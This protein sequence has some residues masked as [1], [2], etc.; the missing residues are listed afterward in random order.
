[1]INRHATI[2][3]SI[4]PSARRPIGILYINYYLLY[5]RYY[6]VIETIVFNYLL[7]YYCC[8]H[9]LPPLATLMCF[10]NRLSSVR[11]QFSQQTV[12]EFDAM[13]YCRTFKSQV[14]ISFRIPKFG[15]FL[16]WSGR[17]RSLIFNYSFRIHRY[18]GPNWYPVRSS[19]DASIHL[20]PCLAQ[21][22]WLWASW[23]P[24][25]CHTTP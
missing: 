8:F 17:Y 10:W 20:Q 16:P 7:Y 3:R 1:M 12:D 6:N 22:K 11:H 19:R 23:T 9:R 14:C 13:A 2:D 18:R 15:V 21:A 25:L 5:Y 24:S 4:A